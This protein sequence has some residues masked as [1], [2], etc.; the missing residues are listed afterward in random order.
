ML[1]PRH[2]T[3]EQHLNSSGK[4]GRAAIPCHTPSRRS[5][6]TGGR[7]F[8]AH[9]GRPKRLRLPTSDKFVVVL[10]T[11][12]P[13][14]FFYY[15]SPGAQASIF[16]QLVATFAAAAEIGCLISALSL[17]EADEP[18]YADLVHVFDRFATTPASMELLGS[19]AVSMVLTSRGSALANFDAEVIGSEQE[20]G[21]EVGS[22][23]LW[24]EL[25]SSCGTQVGF[26]RDFEN[27]LDPE[28]KEAEVFSQTFSPTVLLGLER[29]DPIFC[30]RSDAEKK[31]ESFF[32]F[33]GT[34]SCASFATR[35]LTA[36]RPTCDLKMGSPATAEPNVRR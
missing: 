4:T 6:L 7:N 9:W 15:P 12:D 22:L 31:W 18:S 36:S 34:A 1:R 8:S 30:L 26:K 27:Y 25:L 17:S 28:G 23:G 13:G 24:D 35:S 32:K 2:G 16:R 3:R 20:L 14:R 5:Q 19:Q 11:P 29:A 10:Y 33:S 21:Q